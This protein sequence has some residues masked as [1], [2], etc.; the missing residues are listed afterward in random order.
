MRDFLHCLRSAWQHLVKPP[1]FVDEDPQS[2]ADA[3]A[4]RTNWIRTHRPDK[5]VNR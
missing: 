1:P 2:T 4:V 5:E 3:T